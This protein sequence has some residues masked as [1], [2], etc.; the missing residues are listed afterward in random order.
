MDTLHE[1]K[2][3]SEY[4]AKGF[5]ATHTV[6]KWLQSGGML[7]VFFVFTLEGCVVGQNYEAPKMTLSQTYKDPSA[8]K[9][10]ENGSPAPSLDSWW[11]GFRD[12]QLIRIIQRVLAQNLD[13]EA[14]MARVQQARAAAVG[15]GARE[16]PQG[17]LDASA[18][19]QSQSL[20]S[21]LGKIAS[22]LPGYDRDQTL[23]DF[24]IGASWE[25]DLAGGLKRNA[26]AARDEA[27]AAEAMGAGVRI[28]VAAE[29]ADAYFRVRGTKSRIA[30][31]ERQLEA[32]TK[33]LDLERRRVTYGIAT[34]RDL[35][36]AVAQLAQ[37]SGTLPPLRIELEL[38]LNRLDVLMGAPPGSYATESQEAETDYVIP[39]ISTGESPEELLRRRP[40]VIAAERRFAASIAH[41]GVAIAE[42]YPK[43]SLSALLG[44][45]SLSTKDMFTASSFQPG[46]ITG[47]RWRLFDFGMVDAEVTQAKGARL[48]ALVGYRRAMLRATE[49]VE[50]AITTFSQSSLQKDE[51]LREVKAHE[52]AHETVREEH[53]EGTVDLID[54]LVE[55][56]QLQ[57]VHEALARVQADEARATVA[58]FRALGG[59]WTPTKTNDPVR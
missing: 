33:L 26:E 2:R 51:L 6:R 42:Y 52:L 41:V 36:Q 1:N 13:L 30:I 23:E 29:A 43:V 45:E 20:D 48:E 22:A 57:E 14:A 40:D 32:D 55:N 9:F 4:F 16:M 59:G 34:K 5:L 50:D 18:A 47:L 35:A 15:A 27:Q 3:E 58:V 54:V 7:M 21:P 8:L 19:S 12:P 24:D 56:R 44:F 53:K 39:A 25:L 10:A 17:N 37:D 28:S 31:I 11:T 46:V 38:Q 49:D